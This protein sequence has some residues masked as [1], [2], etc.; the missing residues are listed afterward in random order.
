MR[1]KYPASATVT[2]FRRRAQAAIWDTATPTASSSANV[3]TS[4]EWLMVSRSY[5][6]VK[7]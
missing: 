2:A 6:R 5:G 1:L 4:A 7:K 3:V